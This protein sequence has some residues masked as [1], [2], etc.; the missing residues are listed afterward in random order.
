M[1]NARPP[2]ILTNL[3]RGCFA[4]RVWVYLWWRLIIIV[5]A[6]ANYT[7]TLLIY[8]APLYAHKKKSGIY[9]KVIRRIILGC[10]VCIT[11]SNTTFLGGEIKTMAGATNI[12]QQK[13]T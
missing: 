1:I 2:P 8:S 3:P 9:Y 10:P 4:L 7:K 5:I 13:T 12:K 11:F 6:K